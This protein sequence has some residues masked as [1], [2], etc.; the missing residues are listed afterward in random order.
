G[1]KWAYNQTG[2]VLLGMIIEKV[3]GKAYPQF[4]EESMLKPLGMT[5]TRFGGDRDVIKNLNP[6]W[7]TWENGTLG[8][9]GGISYPTWAYSAA[10]LNSTVR[11]LAKFDAAL[12]A[13]KLLKKASLEQMWA[14]AKLN[15]GAKAGGKVLGYGLG[16]AILDY[17]GHKAVGH[18]GGTN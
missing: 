10:G 9:T 2:Y 3:T 6:A 15:S 16:W 4:V 18:G 14:P 17:Q 13:E 8:R 5:A 11:D 12:S 7:Y 1:E